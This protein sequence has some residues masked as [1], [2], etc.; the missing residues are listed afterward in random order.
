MRQPERLA[1]REVP[2]LREQLRV[3][4][5]VRRADVEEALADLG[6]VE[7]VDQGWRAIA[8]PDSP[9]S[10]RQLVAREPGLAL[11][12]TLD[13]LACGI[14]NPEGESRFASS[15]AEL[16]MSPQHNAGDLVGGR[17]P[18]LRGNLD[19]WTVREQ[20]N[21]SPKVQAVSK[22]SGERDALSVR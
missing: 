13:P 20:G 3:V 9:R 15:E 22:G 18:Q 19:A 4:G 16:R 21:G 11:P 1:G 17:I 7:F 2:L 14:T 5:I 10:H 6:G 12:W 8:S